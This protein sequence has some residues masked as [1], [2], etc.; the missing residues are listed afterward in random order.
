MNDKIKQKEI[1]KNNK[2]GPGKTKEV[3]DLT[4]TII[5]WRMQEVDGSKMESREGK[6]DCGRVGL[7]ERERKKGCEKKKLKVKE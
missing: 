6:F 3:D 4:S 1:I 5:R 2:N 7:S